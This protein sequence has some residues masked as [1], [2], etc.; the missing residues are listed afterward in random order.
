MNFRIFEKV[1]LIPNILSLLFHCVNQEIICYFSAVSGVHGTPTEKNHDKV[2]FIIDILCHFGGT[3]QPPSPQYITS[4]GRNTSG[5]KEFKQWL[6]VIA[7]LI[8][9]GYRYRLVII[10]KY[11]NPRVF[12]NAKVFSLIYRSNI[13]AWVTG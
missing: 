6:I 8:V 13:C 12:K 3:Y 11:F 2:L 5:Y 4:E 1:L 10:V 9:T 7:W